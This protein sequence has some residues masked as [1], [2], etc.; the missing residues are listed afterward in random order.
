[1]CLQVHK[2][3]LGLMVKSNGDAGKRVF[4]EHA[5]QEV[6]CNIDLAWRPSYN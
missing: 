5:T 3:K 4:G 2:E 1:M 6:T